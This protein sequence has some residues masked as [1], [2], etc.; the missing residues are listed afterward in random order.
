[1]KF[2]VYHGDFSQYLSNQNQKHDNNQKKLKK[3]CRFRITKVEL[4]QR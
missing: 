4:R 1:M 2:A 3:P